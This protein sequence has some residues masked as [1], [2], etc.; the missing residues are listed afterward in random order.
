[1]ESFNEELQIGTR[2][3]KIH[4]TSN[5]SSGSSDIIITRDLFYNPQPK[6]KREETTAQEYPY[7]TD[8][9]KYSLGAFKKYSRNR[10]IDTFFNKDQFKLAMN[11]VMDQVPNLK[12]R[13]INAK[14]NIMVMLQLLFPTSFPVRGNIHDTFTENIKNDKTDVP[15]DLSIL[16]PFMNNLISPDDK[17]SFSYIQRNS[18]IYTVLEVYWINDV[19]N[20]PDYS[21]LFRELYHRAHLVKQQYVKNK[22]RMED[23]ETKMI[24]L[25]NEFYTQYND[26]SNN[27]I[28]DEIIKYS[29]NAAKRSTKGVSPE[30]VNDILKK[31]PNPN[32]PDISFKTILSPW[33]ELYKLKLDAAKYN[34]DPNIIPPILLRSFK[35]TLSLFDF[36]SEYEYLVTLE[37]Y[38]NDFSK[39][40]AF[41]KKKTSNMEPWDIE[42]REKMSQSNQKMNLIQVLNQFTPPKRSCSNVTLQKQLNSFL[43]NGIQSNQSQEIINYVMDLMRN[44]K[45]NHADYVN[46]MEIGVVINSD[47]ITSKTNDNTKE[48]KVSD[49]IFA[50]KNNEFYEIYLHLNCIEGILDN[51]NLPLIKCSYENSN[52]VRLYENLKHPTLKKNPMLLYNIFPLIKLETLMPKKTSKSQN[53]KQK[54]GFRPK[55][56]KRRRRGNTL[57]S[58]RTVTGGRKTTR[59]YRSKK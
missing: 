4:F 33:F 7:F 43:K 34:S 19:I 18:S 37:N 32:T 31:L 41:M 1:M 22:S 53:N 17:S 11:I 30:R 44:G 42:V 16:P 29:E 52:L 51:T 5:I 8:N 49:D 35:Q 39:Y 38:S 15:T 20:H 23:I 3:I 46:D 6:D 57:R 9:V 59:K 55:G 47:A 27:S 40:Q 25:Y 2:P 56:T 10:I 14:H 50:E 28:V 12:T 58:A 54:G 36:A 24:K 26:P 21:R 48:A 13:E 45:S